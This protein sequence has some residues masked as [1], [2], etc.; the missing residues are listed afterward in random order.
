VLGDAGWAAFHAALIPLMI[1]ESGTR[2]RSFGSVG[3]WPCLAEM[4]M[5]VLRARPSARIRDTMLPIWASM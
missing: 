1:G 5:A 4:M 3:D 2:A